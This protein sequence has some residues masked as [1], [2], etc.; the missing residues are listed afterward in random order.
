MTLADTLM[1]AA[2][3]CVLV[4]LARYFWHRCYLIYLHMSNRD[5]E[6]KTLP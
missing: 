3:L 6:P 1:L 5:K 2:Y 4:I